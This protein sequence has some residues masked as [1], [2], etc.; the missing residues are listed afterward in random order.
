[1]EG[2]DRE[3]TAVAQELNCLRE[4]GLERDKFLIHG[5]SDRLKRL[6]RRVGLSPLLAGGALDNRSKIARRSDVLAPPA[7]DDRSSDWS[8]PLFLTI[9][10]KNVGK[11]GSRQRIDESSRARTISTIVE[12]HI[13]WPGRTES[14]TPLGG[15]ELI[16]RQAEIEQDTIDRGKSLPARRSLDRCVGGMNESDSIAKMAE[17]NSSPFESGR[18]EIEA[19]QPT[20]RGRPL[21]YRFGVAASTEGSVDVTPARARSK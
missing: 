16:R 9:S 7:L 1:V 18:V 13:E 10:I 21:Q 11:V 2:D 5:D 15:F 4:D 14:E 3:A 12:S 6:R 17:T 19:K 8:C 20:I